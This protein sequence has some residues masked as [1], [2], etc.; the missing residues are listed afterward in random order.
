[1]IFGCRVARTREQLPIEGKGTFSGAYLGQPRAPC[2]GEIHHGRKPGLSCPFAAGG[3]DDPLYLI[4]ERPPGGEGHVGAQQRARLVI[5]SLRHARPEVGD[6]DQGASTH[7]DGRHV[8]QQPLA[9]AATIAP[10][11]ARDPREVESRTLVHRPSVAWGCAGVVDY[12]TAGKADDSLRVV[13][14]V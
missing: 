5:H 11:H 6:G 10:R 12:S 13:G 4:T 14:Q 7:H 8:E 3:G 1:M 2:F 9:V